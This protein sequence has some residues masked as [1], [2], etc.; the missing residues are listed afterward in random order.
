MPSSL[1]TRWPSM[2]SFL[3]G[4]TLFAARA[5]C[6]AHP[7]DSLATPST[8]TVRCIDPRTGELSARLAR[9]MTALG[10]V[11]SSWNSDSTR[12][13]VC[14]LEGAPGPTTP[15]GSGG[16]YVAWVGMGSIYGD[17]YLQR[18]DA[19]GSIAEGWPTGG[20]AVCEA[21]YSQYN[22]ALASDSSGGVFVAWQDFRSG[23]SCDL[24]LQRITGDGT[25][26]PGWPENGR[27][28][29][30]DNADRYMPALVSD[31]RGGA[32]LAWQDR[33]AGRLDAYVVSIDGQGRTRA[34]WPATGVC[35]DH[36]EGTSDGV[37]L[38]RV[39]GSDAIAVW[40]HQDGAGA[41][42]ILAKR[43][44]SGLPPTGTSEALAHATPGEMLLE[45]V[46]LADS[47][48]YFVSWTR[49]SRERSAVELQRMSRQ[50]TANTQWP[51]N[52]RVVAK[53][54]AAF[55]P[56]ILTS[57]GVGGVFVVWEDFN[58]G[59]PCEIYARR[60]GAMGDSVAGWPER[61][62]RVSGPARDAYAPAVSAEGGGLVVSWAV[63][64]SEAVAS[65][66]GAKL[67]KPLRSLRVR[68]A[69]ATPGRARLAW[70]TFEPLIGALSIERRI[71][72][73]GWEPLAEAAIRDSG[74]IRCDDA[75]VPEGAQVEYRVALRT[76]GNTV[77]FAPVTLSIPVAPAMLSVQSARYDATAG[78][79]DLRFSLPRGPEPQ[80]ELMDVAGRRMH[81]QVLSNLEPGE[82]RIRIPLP[83]RMASGMYF[84]RFSQGSQ[85]RQIKLVVVR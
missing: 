43:I 17:V 82:Q 35:L 39:G 21:E 12:R 60:I 19:A 58:A 40:R 72:P 11:D 84:L 5:Q 15:D 70:Q 28:V 7:N 53:T 6:D 42:Q 30:E 50:G 83:S 1:A 16:T 69:R 49:R 56:P 57:D 77:F 46:L 68:E 73:R 14:S 22:I 54:G 81:R 55:F 62:T 45:P 20:L 24:Y 74:L 79:V 10:R 36:D 47:A 32:L 34:G 2:M 41:V 51:A 67:T 13:Q 64:D 80:F 85:M 71:A 18:I 61:G 29:V 38:A 48:G 78:V 76:N 23:Q 27:A 37:T 65:L 31:G 66:L 4:A 44:T 52:G 75:S 3:L 9:R 26:A 63:A 33:R 59:E 8:A 25:V